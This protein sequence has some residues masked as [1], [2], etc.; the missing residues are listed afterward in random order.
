MNS[1]DTN[2]TLYF[3]KSHTFR[4][5]RYI[6]HEECESH[7]VFKLYIGHVGVAI[8]TISFEYLIIEMNSELGS[9][10]C[11]QYLPNNKELPLIYQRM[12]LCARPLDVS[13]AKLKVAA[14]SESNNVEAVISIGNFRCKFTLSNIIISS[15]DCE[16]SMKR[17]KQLDD[18]LF[19]FF[20]YVSDTLQQH[21]TKQMIANIDYLIENKYKMDKREIENRNTM[22]KA[23]CTKKH[24]SYFDNSEICTYYTQQMLKYATL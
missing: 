10:S 13:K 19:D 4:Y 23:C 2:N 1:H 8:S 21:Y 17:T 20:Q 12:W 24:E 7:L 3:Q 16:L 15:G 18:L 14:I 11:I 9:E 5:D 6:G 22:L